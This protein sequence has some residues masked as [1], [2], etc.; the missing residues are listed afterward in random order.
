MSVLFDSG[1]I[2][3][4]LRPEP[5]PDF[6]EWLRTLPRE[7]QFTS[8]V[9]VGELVQG[10][11]ST[12]ASAQARHLRNIEER[13][14]PAVTVLPFDVATA[15]VFGALSAD[16]EGS[17]RLRE[18]DLRIAATAIHHG[19]ELVT[20][21]LRRFREIP[22]LEL[23]PILAETP[24]GRKGR[25]DEGGSGHAGP[26]VVT[27]FRPDDWEEVRL[28]HAEGIAT[29]EATFETEAPSWEAWDVGHLEVARL[30]ARQGRRIVGWAALSPVSS[31]CVYGGVAEV[32]VYVREGCRDR[33]VGARLLARLIEA[34]E[35]HGLW[36]LQ[37][38]VFPEN[39][40]SI[41][42]HRSFGFREV[43]VRERVG[44]LLGRWRDV[45]LL[46]RR[47][48]VVGGGRGG[49][50]PASPSQRMNANEGG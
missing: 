34:S 31:R 45:L 47:S 14:L 39:V 9:C 49:A 13:I 22:G 43:G 48:E 2:L 27:A 8:A 23:A 10:A 42:L 24:S 7:D 36:T 21:D 18:A 35:S 16:A 12:P 33:G 26:I 1:A 29:G 46:E 41:R 37:A 50:L 20:G 28:I 32:S 19:L 17:G 44:R 5:N 6:V 3:E 30:V 40:A 11:L 38:G 4:L 25:G 15:R